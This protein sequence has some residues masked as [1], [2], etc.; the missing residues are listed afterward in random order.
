MK[1]DTTMIMMVGDV[2]VD[3]DDDEGDWMVYELLA[4]KNIFG[5]LA[6]KILHLPK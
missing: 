5:H 2:V 6:P 4:G 3:D 1:Q